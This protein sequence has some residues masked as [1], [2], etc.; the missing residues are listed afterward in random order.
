MPALRNGSNR[1]I[2]VITRI[3]EKDEAAG[4]AKLKTLVAP[5]GLNPSAEAKIVSM[6]NAAFSPS[7]SQESEITWDSVKPL[8]PTEQCPYENLSNPAD[9]VP[10][11]NQLVVVKLNGGLGTTMGCTLPK[12]LIV[13]QNDQTFYDLTLE[14]VRHVNEQYGVNVPLV[15]MQSFDTADLMKPALA[16]TKGV[17]LLTYNQN[18]FP[19]I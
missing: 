19:R 7:I 18:K 14:Q 17:R 6:F 11:L 12:S 3:L 15:L 10:L 2:S 4:T 8:T 9:P 1:V 13:C 16:D 5:L